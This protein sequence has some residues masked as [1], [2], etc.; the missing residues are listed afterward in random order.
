MQLSMRYIKDIQEEIELWEVMQ[1]YFNKEL[2][3]PQYDYYNSHNLYNEYHQV[4]YNGTYDI[5]GHYLPDRQR[6]EKQE[7]MRLLYR[8]KR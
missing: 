5:N 1:E 4:D 8:D 6:M 3:I 7:V 2:D